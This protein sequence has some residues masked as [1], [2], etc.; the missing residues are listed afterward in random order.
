MIISA[1]LLV[2]SILPLTGASVS[3]KTLSY[4]TT[5][6]WY[7]SNDGST[8]ATDVTLVTGVFDSR[9]DWTSQQVLSE[10]F[11]PSS[12]TYDFVRTDDNRY[13]IASVGTLD[14][15]ESKTVTVTQVVQVDS[16]NLNV[17]S[18]MVGDNIP[19]EL[20]QYTV[21]VANLWQSDDPVLDNRAHEIA[22]NYS[23]YYDKARGI[24]DFVRGYLVYTMQT[25]E[26]DALWVYNNRIG[27]CSDATNL[28]IALA[29]AAGIPTKYVC[30]Y[31]YNS[32]S[33][34]GGNLKSMGHAWAIVYLP[35]VGW[36]P[37]DAMR[38]QFGELSYDHL[39]LR[40]SD[41]GDLVHGTAIG[42]IRGS[43]FCSNI[44][45]GPDLSLTSQAT[46]TYEDVTNPGTLTLL[47]YAAIGTAIFLG[48]I[49]AIF[50]FSRRTPQKQQNPSF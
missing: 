5:T 45:A 39:A 8:T 48:A 47:T 50:F 30:G 26:H 9:S 24:F 49:L 27:D 6:T 36:I 14:P 35:D 21:P 29:R 17:T 19:S 1:I 10:D 11:Q 13:A 33:W 2:F 44:G 15:G 23:N 41:G 43:V 38:N 31:E 22:D 12:Y 25:S 18:D 4:R 3:M 28:F 20:S 37:V 7:V 34:Y 40:T 32:S 46:I 16:S 42:A